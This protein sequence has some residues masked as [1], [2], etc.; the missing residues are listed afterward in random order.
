MQKNDSSTT[1]TRDLREAIA[2]IVGFSLHRT[3]RQIGL[4]QIACLVV[5]ISRDT[6]IGVGNRLEFLVLV[7][8]EIG[9]TARRGNGIAIVGRIVTIPQEAIARIDL[10][11]QAL[12]HI[13][14]KSG[15]APAFSCV[16]PGSVLI[17]TF[18]GLGGTP[19]FCT[20][21]I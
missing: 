21:N 18:L 4:N 3:I 9:R 10:L 14:A 19:I 2:Q 15:R 8:G 6:V 7:I 16:S 17:K 11:D 12:P 13:I 20:P 5:S 1:S